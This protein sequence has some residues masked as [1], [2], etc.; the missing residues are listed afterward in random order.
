MEEGWGRVKWIKG[1]LLYCD[2]GKQGIVVVRSLQCIQN[3]NYNVHVKHV[4]NQC[5]LNYK[6]SSCSTQWS[7]CFEVRSPFNIDPSG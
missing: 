2:G 1:V 4:I 6:N 3:L 5:Y 7:S